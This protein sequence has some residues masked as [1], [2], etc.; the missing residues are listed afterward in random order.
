[1]KIK[2]IKIEG[3][4]NVKIKYYQFD[5]IT[6]LY[7]NNGSGKSTILQAIQLCLL[8]Y[9]PGTNKTSSAIF[10]HC[11][12]NKLTVELTLLDKDDEIKCIRSFNKTKSKIEE[13]FN[14]IPDNY[15]IDEIIGNLELPIFNFNEF[16]ALSANKQKDLL[17]SILPNSDNSINIYQYLT[18]LSSYKASLSSILYDIL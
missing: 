9:I 11:N 3:M 6:Y 1:M 18:S 10:E 5:N 13:Q 4:H 2:D 16:L 8:G 7:G 14:I 12:C 17:I 15:L